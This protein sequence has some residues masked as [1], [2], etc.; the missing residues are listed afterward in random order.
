MID[1]LF[2]R[3]MMV[4]RRRRGEVTPAQFDMLERCLWASTSYLLP[5]YFK[6]VGVLAPFVRSV[7]PLEYK[8]AQG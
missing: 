8:P 3:W 6:L 7:S 1:N 2:C 4:G 5:N